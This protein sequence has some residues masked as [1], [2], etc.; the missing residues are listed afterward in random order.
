MG[1]KVMLW[2]PNTFFNQKLTGKKNWYEPFMVQHN[3]KKGRVVI[4]DDALKITEVHLS[5]LKIT[6]EMSE[7]ENTKGPKGKKM[8][9][10]P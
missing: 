6:K 9:D 5:E 1:D 10:E 4:W 3:C 7:N 2:A 8:K